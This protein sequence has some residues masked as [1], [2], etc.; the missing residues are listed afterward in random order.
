[1]C[2]KVREV[3]ERLPDGRGWR[4]G[5]RR[6]PERE[7]RQRARN[8]LRRPELRGA[9]GPN[10]Q[11]RGR[12]IS[13]E[14]REGGTPL[15]GIVG[16]GLR[17]SSNYRGWGGAPGRGLSSLVRRCEPAPCVPQGGPGE[18]SSDVEG[19]SRELGS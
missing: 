19:F 7:I 1:M 15:G 17:G 9:G 4:G 2:S 18:G 12:L 13:R 8:L 10:A 5:A 16:P 3:G 6:H 14:R 11:P